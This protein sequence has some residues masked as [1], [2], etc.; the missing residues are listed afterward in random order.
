VDERVREER[1]RWVLD[2]AELSG[3]AGMLTASLP[4]GWKQRV[5][6][7]AAVM[8]EPEAIFLDEPTS[9]VDPLA[10]RA[11]WRMINEFA[12][13]G[14]GILV[15][16]HYLEEAEQC[17]RLGFMVAGEIIAAGSP[18]EVKAAMKGSLSE[19][20]T[21]QPERALTVLKKKF[22]PSRVSLFGDKLHLVAENDA[23][24]K[25]AAAELEAAGVK[26]TTWNP[27]RFSLEDVFIS[28]IESRRSAIPL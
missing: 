23:Q 22:G 2:T 18:G 15:V 13:R 9:G 19:I 17:N 20:E 26:V 11:M 16:T 12:D 7:G 14:A 10:R 4:G 1:K 3:E 27:A 5:A 25:E 28:L 21:D 8:H 24:E 6:F